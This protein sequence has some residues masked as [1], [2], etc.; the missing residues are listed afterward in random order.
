MTSVFS[1]Q[2]SVSLCLA[3]F[4][5]PRPNLPVTTSISWLLTFA[6]QSPMMKM[7]SFL[8]LVL[9]DLVDLHRIIIHRNVCIYHH[10]WKLW[11]LCLFYS[12]SLAF[13]IFFFY[14]ICFLVQC[15]KEGK[16]IGDIF[17]FLRLSILKFYSVGRC[18]W[19]SFA[20]I[21][22]RNKKALI[23]FPLN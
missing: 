2:N 12:N 7:A 1:W 11:L 10:V 4:C 18:F 20:Y 22:Y 5:T 8:M 17:F 15:W 13:S 14:W 6:F 23:I 16:L 3:S 21:N 9:E 19:I